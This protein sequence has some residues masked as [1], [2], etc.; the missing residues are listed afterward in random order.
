MKRFLKWFFLCLLLIAIVLAAL[1]GY[2]WKVAFGPGSTKEE[3][4]Q[5][6]VNDDKFGGRAEQKAIRYGDSILPLI[7]NDSANFEKLN[8]RNSFWIAEV[9]GKIRTEKS[10]SILSDLY[11]RTN[12]IAR[13][14]GAIGLLEQGVF[15]E[16]ITDDS[17]LVQTVKNQSVRTETEAE[18]AIIALGYSKDTNA[19]PC[20]LDLL[21][22]QP[23]G[24]WL[25]A[26]ACEAVARIG[27]PEAIPVLEDCLKSEK[28]YAFPNAFRA[29]IALGDKQ[30]VPLAIARVSPDIKMQ[31]SGFVVGELKK[32]TGKSF[33]YDRDAWQK[34]WDSVK[35][36]W[37]IP[38][39]YLKPWDE[40]KPV[41]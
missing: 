34:W 5:I 28:F 12:Q 38:K 30:A 37:E 39:D 33:G 31:N 27:S 1:V 14:T 6:L 15:P 32:V 22:N 10:R 35:T 4:A 20:L 3:T 29:L 41:Y 17:L 18:L 36:T 25:H 2:V 19:L 40:Q 23:S 11:S 26:Y 16:K 13:L 21:K 8:G 7:Q 9:L 24:Y